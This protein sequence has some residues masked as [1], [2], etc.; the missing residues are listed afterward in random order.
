MNPSKRYQAMGAMLGFLVLGWT[1][2]SDAS[3]SFDTCQ[4]TCEADCDDGGSGPNCHEAEGGECILTDDIECNSTTVP[5]VRLRDGTDLDLNGNTITCQANVDCHDAVSMLSSG[6]KV[7]D[8]DVGEGAIVGRF[9]HGVDCALNATSEVTGIKIV[10]TLVGVQN[11]KTIKQNVITGLGRTF[12]TGN[13]GIITEGV[14]ASG[15]LI[16]K[17]YIADKSAAIFISGADTVEASENVFHTSTWTSCAVE[18]ASSSATA[19]VLT[20]TVF[21]VGNVGAGSTRKI[22]CLNPTEPTGIEIAGNLCDEDHPDCQN[23][24]DD[25]FC[26]PFDAP[27]LP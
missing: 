6:S 22:F 15:D 7:Y 17:N 2:S 14:T 5:V 23:C 21:G 16:S 27:F 18:L 8:S 24:Q 4:I 26:E 3:H 1:G 12:L 13:W 10:D 20:N 11:C 19:Q 9:F 25:G